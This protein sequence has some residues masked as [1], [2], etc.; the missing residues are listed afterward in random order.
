[1]GASNLTYPTFISKAETAD[2]T[3]DVPDKPSAVTPQQ[4]DS[5]FPQAGKKQ[6][7]FAA[8]TLNQC[9]NEVLISQTTQY[10]LDVFLSR[11]NMLFAVTLR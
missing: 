1:M 5:S 11:E 4:H 10:F 8:T 6:K 2:E 9:S 3:S 7:G